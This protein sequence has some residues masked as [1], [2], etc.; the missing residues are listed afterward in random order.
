MAHYPPHLL[1]KRVNFLTQIKK[2]RRR[3]KVRIAGIFLSAKGDFYVSGAETYVFS[4]G[5]HVSGAET[6]VSRPET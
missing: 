2:R 5:I 6:Q 3:Q 4:A 1:R